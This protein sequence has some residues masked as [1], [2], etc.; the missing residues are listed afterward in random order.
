MF[1]NE[2]LV[3]PS[4]LRN[5]D[6]TVFRP[7][8]ASAA[9]ARK[10]PQARLIFTG[11]IGTLLYGGPTEGELARRFYASLGI[12][13]ERVTIEICPPGV[14]PYSG[15]NEE[16]CTRNSCMASTETRLLVPP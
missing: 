1:R 9:L 6:T 10:Y 5:G 15:A 3:F 12:A 13:P 16:V 11:G 8:T 14:R 4:R 7:L 2:G